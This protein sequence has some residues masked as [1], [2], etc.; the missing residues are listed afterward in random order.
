MP[1]Q[2]TVLF[3]I[4]QEALTNIV[5]HARASAVSVRLGARGRQFEMQIR[6]NGRG[7]TDA[8]IRDPRAIG[9]LGMRERAMLIGGTF[10]IAGRRGSGTAIVVR[11]SPRNR[12]R[13]MAMRSTPRVRARRRT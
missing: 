3:R 4:F 12:S 2:E 11:V 9:L 1:D 5:R 8:Q 10:E 13:P 7:I 6:D